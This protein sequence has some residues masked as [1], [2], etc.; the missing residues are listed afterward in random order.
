MPIQPSP[1]RA[2]AEIDLEALRHNLRVSRESSGG[3]VMAV[4]KAGAYGHGLE[5]I[6]RIL[7]EENI[8]FFGVAN[9]GEA[10]RIA[11]SG[12]ATPIYL[13]GATWSEERAEIVARGW[14]PCIS[15]LDE[16]RHFSELAQASNKCLR[17]HLAIDTGMGRGGF[18]A[19]GLPEILS[20]LEALPG[21]EVEGIGSHLPSADED[22]A[23]TCSQFASFRETINSLGGPARF[24]WI[25]LSNSAG[26][27][28]YDNHPCNLVRPGL[29]LYGISPIPGFQDKLQNVMTLKS[30]VTLVRTLPAGHGISYGRA[31]VTTRE[32]RV[33]TVGIGYGD[34]YPRHLSGNGA[35]VVIRDQRFPLLGRVTM[36]QIMIDVTGSE[37]T[38]GDEVELFGPRIRVDEVAAKAGTI[39]WEILTGITPRVVR[40]HL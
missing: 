35:E 29:M 1:P 32:T 16:A 37:V 11:D 31:F 6:A 36:D 18:V 3:S 34:G 19:R 39:A 21:I 40:I 25:H 5:E 26:L 15:S 7:A 38:A 23:F 28:G 14:T 20:E 17:V 22:E 2:W 13:L 12:V 10:R 27:L 24:K 33:A 30:R 9:V 8:A 4:V